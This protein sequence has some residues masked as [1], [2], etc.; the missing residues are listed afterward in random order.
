M[1]P[2]PPDK[3]L[4]FDEALDVLLDDRVID[5]VTAS[6]TSDS[7]HQATRVGALLLLNR[8]VYGTFM[9]VESRFNPAAYALVSEDWNIPFIEGQTEEGALRAGLIRA[10]TNIN[11]VKAEAAGG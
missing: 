9:W 6:M 1:L 11:R 4:T 3:E 2:F 5:C 8:D 10:A 7:W